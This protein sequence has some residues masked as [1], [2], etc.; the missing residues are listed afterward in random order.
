MHKIHAL[1]M[2]IGYSLRA[3]NIFTRG[4]EMLK[5]EELWEEYSKT[6]RALAC[7][8]R[9]VRDNMRR[10]PVVKIPGLAL[11]LERA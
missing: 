6:L 8:S 1:N 7:V 4:V 10:F 2:G 11:A 5:K 9:G 3:I